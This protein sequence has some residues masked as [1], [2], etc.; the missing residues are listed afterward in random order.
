MENSPFKLSFQVTDGMT[1]FA[2]AFLRSRKDWERKALKSA[3]WF[4]QQQIKK[5]IRSGA[6]GGKSY[7]AGIGSIIDANWSKRKAD[8]LFW[9]KCRIL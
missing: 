8:F 2:E 6:P 5:G 9:E 7:K 3:G 1:P 4:G